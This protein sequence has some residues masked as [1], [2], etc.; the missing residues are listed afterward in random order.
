AWTVDATGPTGTPV[1]PKPNSKTKDATPNKKATVTNAPN[2]LVRSDIEVFVDN[3]KVSG[4]SYDPSSGE[5]SFTSKKL[6]FKK[7][8]VKIVATDAAGNTTTSQW[9][10]TVKKKRR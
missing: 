4:F 6:S 10:F 7:H 1:S 2:G 8:T 5:L 9:S 3:Q